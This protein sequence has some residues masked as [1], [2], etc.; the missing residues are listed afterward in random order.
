MA[1]YKLLSKLREE[2]ESLNTR[3]ILSSFTDCDDT[4]EHLKPCEGLKCLYII[5]LNGIEYEYCYKY[6]ISDNIYKTLCECKDNFIEYELFLIT[7]DES[8]KQVEKYLECANR[9]IIQTKNIR[10]HINNL[11]DKKNAGV[12][13]LL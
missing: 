9:D 2:D 4:K 5:K 10:Y 8:L 3:L 6:G 11:M 12:I 1:D 7:G 13:Q